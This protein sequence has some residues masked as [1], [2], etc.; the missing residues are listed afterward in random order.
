MKLSREEQLFLRH[1]MHDEVH[2]HDGTGPAKRLQLQ[3]GAVPADLA[4]LIAAAISDISEQDAAGKGPPPK[5]PAA[6][7]VV[8]GRN[9]S[10]RRRGSRRPGRWSGHVSS[11][12]EASRKS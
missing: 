6:L 7:A 8:D 4:V 1:W 2:Y 3:Y 12:N 9:S 11:Q 10:A 5:E